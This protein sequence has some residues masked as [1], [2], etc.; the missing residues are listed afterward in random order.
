MTITVLAV[1]MELDIASMTASVS[2]AHN[3]VPST[4]RSVPVRTM[5]IVVAMKQGSTLRMSALSYVSVLYK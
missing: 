3:T 2:E 4:I 1:P 5:V